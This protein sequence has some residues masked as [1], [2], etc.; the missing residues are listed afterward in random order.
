MH[1]ALNGYHLLKSHVFKK[2]CAKIVDLGKMADVLVTLE[3]IPPFLFWYHDTLSSPLNWKLEIYGLVH[4]CWMY[5]MECYMKTNLCEKQ[6]KAWREHGRRLHNKRGIKVLHR[7]LT[8]LYNHKT[9]NMG[10]KRNPCMVDEVVERNGHPWK[11]VVNFQEMA[12]FFV[13]Q[14]VE[15]M[16]PWHS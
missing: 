11:L 7:I 9:K 15:L 3:I 13:L 5:P 6:S 16:D 8:K 1:E 4:T 2:L 10:C 14:N 12:H